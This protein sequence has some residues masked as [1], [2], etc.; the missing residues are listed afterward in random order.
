MYPSASLAGG[1]LEGLGLQITYPPCRRSKIVCVEFAASR[2]DRIFARKDL[3]S[4]QLI[5]KSLACV[6]VVE[7]V[8]MNELVAYGVVQTKTPPDIGAVGGFQ[9][10]ML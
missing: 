4:D 1:G 8:L 7:L 10:T 2:C 5:L 6:D 3:A 9:A